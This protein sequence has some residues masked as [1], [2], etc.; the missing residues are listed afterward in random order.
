MRGQGAIHAHVAVAVALGASAL[1]GLAPATVHAAVPAV[2]QTIPVGVHG[3]TVRLRARAG[4]TVVV[5]Q[6]RV[7]RSVQEHRYDVKGAHFN[8]ASGLDT[9]HVRASFGSGGR[10]DLSFHARG[11]RSHLDGPDPCGILGLYRDPAV[12]GRPGR[13]TGT[14]R[15][16]V[17][18]AYFGT[19]RRLGATAVL[20]RPARNS[21][22]ALASCPDFVYD[23]GSMIL[24]STIRNPRVADF[25]FT[26]FPHGAGNGPPET[27][28]D[29]IV[30]TDA[31]S[32]TAHHVI[33]GLGPAS[34]FV[35]FDDYL[36]TI[37]TGFGPFVSGSVRYVEGDQ[38]TPGTVEGALTAHFDS[39]GARTSS[40][41]EW[42]LYSFDSGSH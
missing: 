29:V 34:A 31:P 27:G 11:R 30:V 38:S 10:L 35:E 16:P 12:T 23:G 1:G 41:G 21:R 22:A 39:I 25:A 8:A 36:N 3:Y 5:L 26:S 24:S 14:F 7:G 42:K 20:G 33:T 9:A 17:G 37:A 18:D 2:L 28:E 40:T 19:L 32:G 13:V 15:F 6:R 4:R